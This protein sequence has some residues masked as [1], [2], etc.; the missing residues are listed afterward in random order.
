LEFLATD[1]VPCGDKEIDCIVP[2]QKRR[3]AVLKDGS[4]LRV[5]MMAT[6]GTGIG[7]AVRHAMKSGFDPARRAMALEAIAL[8]HKM[9]KASVVIREALK[10]LAD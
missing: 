8:L 3:P 6:R 4:G 10:E 7:F 9:L 5:D 2:T 1:A